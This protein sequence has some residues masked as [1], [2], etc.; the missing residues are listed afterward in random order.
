MSKVF[1][2]DTTKQPLNPVHPARA[3]KLLDVG[4]AAI[5]RRYPF[6]II[7]KIAIEEPV[8]A[9]FQVKLDP[10]SKTT[11]IAIVDD[12]RGEVVFAAE[13]SHHG[14]AIKE[15]LDKRRGV[16]RGRRFR[17]THCRKARWQNRRRKSGWLPPSLQSRIAN[18]LTWVLRLRKFCK[19]TNISLELGRFDMQLME[20]PEILGV[21]YQQGTHVG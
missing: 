13:L 7:L 5:Y 18:V 2:V 4:K 1:V 9:D 16:R 20:N 14:H 3:R 15:S 12:K 8:V 11:G 19:I 10:G 6:T 17:H 21:E